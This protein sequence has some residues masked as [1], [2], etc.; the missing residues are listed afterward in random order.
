MYAEDYAQQIVM[1]GFLIVFV[2]AVLSLIIYMIADYC[3]Q[4]FQEPVIQYKIELSAK[5]GQDYEEYIEQWLTDR[6]RQNGKTQISFDFYHGLFDKGAYSDVLRRE[7]KSTIAKWKA[8]CV[9]IIS[10][11]LFWKGRKM[12]QFKEMAKKVSSFDYPIFQ[13]VFYRIRK[14]SGLEYM[15][16]EKTIEKTFHQMLEIDREL[17]KMGYK[18]TRKKSTVKEQKT[19]MNKELRKKIEKRDKYTCRIC[20]KYMPDRAGLKIGYVNSSLKEGRNSE[21]NLRVLCSECFEKQ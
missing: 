16:T 4:P 11:S 15:V 9:Q 8:A 12:K 1:Y 21:K 14:N 3:K 20:G 10:K 13:F 17:C 19:F 7:R 6:V 2:L 5:K 18:R